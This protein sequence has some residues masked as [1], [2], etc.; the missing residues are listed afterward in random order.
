MPAST[1]KGWRRVALG[2]IARERSERAGDSGAEVYAVTK[3]SG[4]VRSADYFDRQV[5]SRNV[6]EYR[7]VRRGDFGYAT[8]HLDEGSIGLFDA[9]DAGLIS[10][11]YTVFETDP[12]QVDPKFLIACLKQ[13]SMVQTY[14][15]LG[16]GSIHRRK[17]IRFETLA[18][19]DLLLPPL[20]EQRTIAAVLDA[21]DETIERTEAVIAATEALRGALLHELLTRGVPG[22]H[23]KWR[24]VPGLGTVPACWD[25]TTLGEVVDIRSGQA[26]PRDPA[27]QHLLFIAPDDIE[28][29][30]GRLLTKR[31][32]A[33]VQAISGKYEFDEGDVIYSKIRPYLMKVYLPQERGLC[34]AD[35]YPIRPNAGLS[36]TYLALVLLSPSFTDYART[37]SDRTG[38]PKINRPALLRFRL[39]LPLKEEQERI[40][41]VEAGLQRKRDAEQ[42][43]LAELRAL[44][45]GLS[46]A[47]LTG[48]LR[49]PSTHTERAEIAS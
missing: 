2:G 24:D 5:F 23:S 42:Q 14:G 15:R 16:N 7:L 25:V 20:P 48:R 34:S 21:V 13:P 19:V 22:M 6:S 8:I 32:V 28:S 31:T 30:T 10:P 29:G 17:S 43:Q 27:L 44:K 1:P 4:F 36:R 12:E 11:I 47:L 9:A 46:D 38:I 33:D 39:P 49:V 37:C 41:V 45:A 18:K 40:A 3:H 26:D 35:M